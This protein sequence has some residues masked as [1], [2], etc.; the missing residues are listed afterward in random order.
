MGTPKYIT[1]LNPE[2]TRHLRLLSIHGNNL[3]NI[4]LKITRM[5]FYYYMNLPLKRKKEKK[6]NTSES[7]L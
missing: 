6:R 1:F 5:V 7:N 4:V 3:K 2:L